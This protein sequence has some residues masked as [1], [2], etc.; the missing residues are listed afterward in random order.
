LLYHPKTHIGSAWFRDAK[1]LQ[2][3]LPTNAFVEVALSKSARSVLNLKLMSIAQRYRNHLDTKLNQNH[4]KSMRQRDHA[5]V[6]KF[7]MLMTSK[8]VLLMTLL[9]ILLGLLIGRMF[10]EAQAKKYA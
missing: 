1:V 3:P 2:R 7:H 9:F 8:D 10:L 6:L 5:E 4:L